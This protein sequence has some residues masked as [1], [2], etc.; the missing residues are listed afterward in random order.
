ML[1]KTPREI[2]SFKSI[3]LNELHQVVN[4]YLLFGVSFNRDSGLLVSRITKV[5][6][7][8]IQLTYSRVPSCGPASPWCLV[9]RRWLDAE[10]VCMRE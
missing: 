6:I 5:P 1:R 8:D 10:E 4:C 3:Q 9:S 2:I 7:C